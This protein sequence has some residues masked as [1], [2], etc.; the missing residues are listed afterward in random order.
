MAPG[1][2]VH[3]ELGLAR[4]T[5][6]SI[7]AAAASGPNDGRVEVVTA[8]GPPVVPVRNTLDLVF[9]GGNSARRGDTLVVMGPKLRIEIVNLSRQ[10]VRLSMSAFAA[11]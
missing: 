6:V 4:F 7:L 2:R 11:K 8:F 9:G 3:R 10:P 5:R 1:E